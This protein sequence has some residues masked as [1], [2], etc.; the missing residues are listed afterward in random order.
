MLLGR[1]R[2]VV[3][4]AF[5]GLAAAACAKSTNAGSGS[6]ST[7]TVSASSGTPVSLPGKVTNKGT[8]DLS[9]MGSSVHFTLE[10][11]ND[12]GQFYFNPT[13]LKITP[14]SKITVELE[15]DGST[16]HNFSIEA[17]NI[18]QD[19]EKGQKKTITF[20]LPA[21]GAVNFFCEYHHKLGMQGAFFSTAGQ[22]LVPSSGGSTSGSTSSTGGSTGGY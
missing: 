20:T 6:S 21:N 9:A 16:E 1:A 18:N 5:L 10:A 19:L 17:L 13:F 7:P 8:K 2:L 14:G 4:L 3:V 12:D 15:N 22:A 11:D